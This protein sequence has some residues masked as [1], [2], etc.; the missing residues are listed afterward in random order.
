MSQTATLTRQGALSPPDFLVQ[1]VR[2]ETLMGSV[3][4]GVSQDRSDMDIYGFC[5]PPA[6]EAFPHLKGHIPGFGKPTTP[7]EQFQQHHARLP[8]D[9]TIYDLNIYSIVRFVSLCMENNPNMIES[10]FTPQDCVLHTSASA[11]RLREARSSMLHKG[12]WSKFK[13]FTMSQLHKMNI[14][15]PKPNSKRAQLVEKFGY[16]VKF[17]YHA[18]RLLDFADQM[19][20]SAD[21]DMSRKRDTL[22][23]IRQGAWTQERLVSFCELEMARLDEVCK[24]SA[25]PQNADKQMVRTLLLDCLEEEYGS[26][27]GIVTR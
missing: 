11:V 16:D 23:E 20:T 15:Q 21:L 5:I 24:A 2:Y 14:K 8:D 17:G 7:F 26:L 12:L 19:L 6:P 22:I 27:E 3:A 4:Y 25:L 1:S 9:P 10:L 18:V 13:G